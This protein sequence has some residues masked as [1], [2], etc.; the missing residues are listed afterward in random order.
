MIHTA[1]FIFLQTL[2]S[3]CHILLPAICTTQAKKRVKKRVKRDFKKRKKNKVTKN[4]PEGDSNPDPQ[5]QLELKVNASI[6]WITS[7]NACN[8]SLKEVRIP[9]L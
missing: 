9:T 3:I 2:L 4:L 8:L 6:H 5:N 7:V 1:F